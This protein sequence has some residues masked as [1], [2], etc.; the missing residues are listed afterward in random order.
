MYADDLASSPLEL[1][2][3]LDI[4]SRYASHWQ[5]SLNADKSVA[6]GLGE[7][8]KASRKWLL[9]DQVIKEVDMN[10]IIRFWVFCG[11]YTCTSVYCTSERCTSERSVF[12][13][14][15]YYMAPDV[16]PDI[17]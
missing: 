14:L 1:Q 10:N 2:Q 6:M 12:F 8:T 4:V 7:I 15:N 3:M 11:L 17:L 9:G 16:D 5:Y 13:A